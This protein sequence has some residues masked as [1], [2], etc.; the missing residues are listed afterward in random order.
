MLFFAV[1]RMRCGYRVVNVAVPTLHNGNGTGKKHTNVAF[2]QCATRA[3]H[4]RASTGP[5]NGDAHHRK[6]KTFPLAEKGQ[7]GEMGKERKQKTKSRRRPKQL[8]GSFHL[9]RLRRGLPSNVRPTIRY[10]AP[11]ISSLKVHQT[12]FC[13]PVLPSCAAP[14]NSS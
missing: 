4:G 8:G 6:Q 13:R 12:P 10:T 1:A 14:Y 7:K 5:L 2:V 3:L 9:C 11:V